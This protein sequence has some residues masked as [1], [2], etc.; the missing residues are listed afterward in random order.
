MEKTP[1]LRDISCSGEIE[2]K[3]HRIAKVGVDL[4]IRM[5]L[6]WAASGEESVET[7][8]SEPL[9]PQREVFLRGLSWV[10]SK[11]VGEREGTRYTA[12]DVVW[13]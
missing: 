3:P 1:I 5:E 10:A 11:G 7:R 13:R 6:L 4:H 8:Y 12:Q 2:E 9:Q